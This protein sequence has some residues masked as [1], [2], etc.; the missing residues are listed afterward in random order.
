MISK[1][2]IDSFLKLDDNELK[3]KITAAALA[4]GADEKLIKNALSDMSKL[5]NTVSNLSQS[6]IDNILK[7]VDKQNLQKIKDALNI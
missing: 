3:S 5:K 4:G 1:D 7:S 2:N 6:D